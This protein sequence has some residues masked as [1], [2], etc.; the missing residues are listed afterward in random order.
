MRGKLSSGTIKNEANP[1]KLYHSKEKHIIN[2]QA[3][4]K[5]PLCLTKE[6]CL[7]KT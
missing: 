1:S 2:C 5:Y 4:Y 3:T 7:R 6:S